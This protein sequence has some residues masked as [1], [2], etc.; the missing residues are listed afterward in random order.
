[1]IMKIKLIAC[2]VLFAFNIQTHAHEPK[3]QR[4]GAP[5]QQTPTGVPENW[6][7][8]CVT[9]LAPLFKEALALY[10][11]ESLLIA[12]PYGGNF[13]DSLSKL[14][15]NIESVSQPRI[16]P[17]IPYASIST[18]GADKTITV[19]RAKKNRHNGSRLA[20]CNCGCGP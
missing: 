10:N 12:K 2:A 19:Y 4:I 16:L 6:G 17:K 11:K 20:L 8:Y 13:T 5:N 18:P 15:Q 9:E 3:R 14:S 1:M 7:T